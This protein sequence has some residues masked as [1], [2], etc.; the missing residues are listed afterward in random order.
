MMKEFIWGLMYEAMIQLLDAEVET[1]V[2]SGIDY[3]KALYGVIGVATLDD[4]GTSRRMVV[5]KQSHN[6]TK[7][8]KTGENYRGKSHGDALGMDLQYI[9][10]VFFFPP[11]SSR[12]RP[13]N[14]HSI[15]FTFQ[16]VKI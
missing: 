12:K 2:G 9:H 7:R 13:S 5:G 8:D 14:S 10:F 1:Q 16:N 15:S 11:F 6:A 4:L 3:V